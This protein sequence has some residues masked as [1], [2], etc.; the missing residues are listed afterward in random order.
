MV[1]SRLFSYDK[2]DITN[3]TVDYKNEFLRSIIIAS[4]PGDQL[5]II[6]QLISDPQDLKLR[7]VKVIASD[8]AEAFP[9]RCSWL[10]LI[11]RGKFM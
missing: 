9:V 2:T 6:L 4:D 1:E 8:P 11:A 10:L 3:T 5:S 7:H